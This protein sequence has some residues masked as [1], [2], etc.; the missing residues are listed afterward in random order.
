MKR[1]KGIREWIPV[2][3][4][5]PNRARHDEDE[6]EGRWKKGSWKKQTYRPK[7]LRHDDEVEKSNGIGQT[8]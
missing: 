5:R 2:V 6:A 8:E 3:P 1:F 4:M 7:N